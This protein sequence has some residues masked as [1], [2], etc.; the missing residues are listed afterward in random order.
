MLRSISA[1][2]LVGSHHER[3]NMKLKPPLLLKAL[4][5]PSAT[6]GGGEKS[7]RMEKYSRLKMFFV[8]SIQQKEPVSHVAL[9]SPLHHA[10]KEVEKNGTTASLVGEEELEKAKLRF[11]RIVK[12]LITRQITETCMVKKHVR[13]ESCANLYENYMAAPP[14]PAEFAIFSRSIKAKVCLLKDREEVEAIGRSIVAQVKA[15]NEAILHC[16]KHPTITDV[17]G[18]RFEIKNEECIA[19]MQLYMRNKKDPELCGTACAA[20]MMWALPENELCDELDQTLLDDRRTILLQRGYAVMAAETL[21]AHGDDHFMGSRV[22]RY[23]TALLGALSPFLLHEVASSRLDSE[24][25]CQGALHSFVQIAKEGKVDKLARIGCRE[26]ILDYK[27]RFSTDR[28]MQLQIHSLLRVLKRSTIKNLKVVKHHAH[29]SE[30]EIEAIKQ[31]FDEM[32]ED[33]TGE[34]SFE[35]VFELFRRFGG[36]RMTHQEMEEVVWAIDTDKSGTISFQE[37]LF[38]VESKGGIRSFSVESQFSESKLKEFRLAFDRFDSDKSG[39]IDAE[40]LGK[41]LTGVGVRL[42]QREIQEIMDE[43][44]KNQSGTLDWC[45]FLDIMGS[46]TNLSDDENTDIFAAAFKVLGGKRGVIRLKTLKTK[47]AEMSKGEVTENDVELMVSRIKM[48]N[49]FSSQKMDT[50]DFKEFTSFIVRVTDL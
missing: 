29:Y 44:D 49:K 8:D 9:L 24:N 41:V 31:Q 22:S 23:S 21:R 46:F 34:V 45:E 37:F 50:L 17:P 33:G 48:E 26:L 30:E 6:S 20:G 36:M 39:E 38:L 10:I 13:S 43:H 11:K 1:S 16:M 32:D 3:L 18:R 47:I 35:K 42:S 5:I 4:P 27:T 7:Q 12:N 25:T 40:E 2:E 14:M 19:L 28:M 15:H